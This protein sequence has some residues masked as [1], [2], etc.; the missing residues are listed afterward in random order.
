MQHAAAKVLDLVDGCTHLD[1]CKSATPVQNLV[2]VI[3]YHNQLPTCIILSQI[4][5]PSTH[6][7]AKV[8]AVTRIPVP[9]ETELSRAAPFDMA[10]PS[11]PPPP[12][13]RPLSPPPL[14]YISSVKILNSLSK[15]QIILQL[16]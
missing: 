2:D 5:S 11:M 14:N 13:Q 16:V 12:I 10:P 9:L 3:R 4:Q 6:H 1:G 7:F 8:V 15:Y